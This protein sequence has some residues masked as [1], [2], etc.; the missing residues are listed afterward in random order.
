MLTGLAM[1]AAIGLIG[2]AAPAWRAAT[3]PITHVHQ[4][5]P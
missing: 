1:A 5:A 3:D 4:G 2:G